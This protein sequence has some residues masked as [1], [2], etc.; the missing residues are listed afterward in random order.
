MK[1]VANQTATA[2][3]LTLDQE[4]WYVLLSAA[5]TKELVYS[6]FWQEFSEDE[7]ENLLCAPTAVYPDTHRLSG[8]MLYDAVPEITKHAET[9]EDCVRQ[10]AL[11]AEC[12]VK[13]NYVKLLRRCNP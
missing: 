13:M 3:W 4:Q 12:Y 10:A 7:A 2:E 6:G 8:S 11:Y 5:I 9:T 1:V